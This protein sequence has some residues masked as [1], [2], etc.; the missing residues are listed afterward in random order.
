MIFGG[1]LMGGPWWTFLGIYDWP[2]AALA[3][4][5]AC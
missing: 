4:A 3:T 2:W 5:L 1:A